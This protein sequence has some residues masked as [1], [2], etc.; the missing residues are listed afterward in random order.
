MRKRRSTASPRSSS[1]RKAILNLL[2]TFH[3]LNQP[4]SAPDRR[5]GGCAPGITPEQLAAA[6]AKKCE[7]LAEW[8]QD[9]VADRTAPVFRRPGDL[10]AGKQAACWRCCGRSPPRRGRTSAMPTPSA[11]GS[12]PPFRDS[13]RYWASR[14]IRSRAANISC[15]AGIRTRPAKG[16]LD[17]AGLVRAIQ[18]P[19]FDKV[20]LV[21]SE[22]FFPAK[23]RTGLT[24]EST[25]CWRRR[26]LGWLEGRTAR[27][28]A[29]A[30]H[31][32]GKPR[33]SIIR[34][35][36]CPTPS[37]CSLSRSSWAR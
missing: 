15:R 27:H 25:T 8:G 12:P 22:T 11:S 9:A 2:P 33:L 14:P 32:E 35:P 13:C 37:G 18:S 5:S 29:A 24:I 34:S 1:I 16:D 28:P 36:T 4:T 3:D 21:D 6:T 17:L 30:L 31:A 20:G 10:Y 19:L 26:S 7:G 23:D